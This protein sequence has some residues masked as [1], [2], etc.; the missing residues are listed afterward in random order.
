[1]QSGAN[2]PM[3]RVV[4]HEARQ[5]AQQYRTGDIDA[6]AETVVRL[7]RSMDGQLVGLVDEARKAILVDR[8]AT[9]LEEW[10][11]RRYS[12]GSFPGGS[13]LVD[14]TEWVADLDEWLEGAREEFVW[15]HPEWR[16]GD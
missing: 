3:D 5:I 6:I 10:A 11:V 4:R 16:E 15:M 2:R 9:G 12:V 14:E 7:G 1:M 13:G 8:R